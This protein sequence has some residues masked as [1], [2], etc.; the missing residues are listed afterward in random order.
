MLRLLAI[1]IAT[2]L[3]SA[4]QST[5]PEETAPDPDPPNVLLII[6]DDQAWTDYGFMGHEQIE[7]PRL[8]RLAS[9]SLTF[10]RAYVTAPLCSPSLATIMTGLY[11]HQHGITGNDPLFEWEGRRYSPE[12]NAE[13]RRRFDPVLKRFLD[14]T[15]LTER[16]AEKHYLSLQT[17]KLWTGSWRDSHFTHGMT[18]GDPERGGRHGDEGLTIGREGLEPIYRFMEEAD[19]LDRPF[20]IWYAPFLPHAPHTPPQELE[21]KYLEIAPTPAIARYW[22][23]CEWFDQTCGALL[24]HLEEKGLTE[25]TLVVYV[26]D[27]GWIQEPDQPN[28]YAERSK[29]SPYEGGIRTPFMFKLPGKI[30]ARMDTTTLAGSIDIVPTILSICELAPDET[31]PGVNVLDREALQQRKTIFAEA[32]DHDIAD[33]NEPTRSL[34]YRIGLEYP[35]KLILPDTLNLPKATPELFNTQTDPFENQDLATQEPEIVQRLHREIDA[36]WIPAHYRGKE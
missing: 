7:T 31:L 5:R 12:W 6:S 8:D 26:C 13:R 15:L 27:N 9:E 1:S 21:A 32:Y 22:A 24:D 19:S 34:Q 28:R 36:W 18:H 17:G 11:P 3:F 35:W 30:E 33:V 25:N 23:M 10:S 20:F 14:Q 16:L 4:C 29:R 2:L